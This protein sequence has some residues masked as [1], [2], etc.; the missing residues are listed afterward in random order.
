MR[1]SS[2]NNCQY[3]HSQHKGQD[4][5]QAARLP[6]RT[7]LMPASC[8]K[9]LIRILRVIPRLRHVFRDDVQTLALLM[10]HMRH[11]PEQ[12]VQLSHRLL[13]VAYLRFS[14]DDQGLVEVDF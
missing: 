1:V 4:N 10:H 5:Q 14:L 11:I 8:P 2:K 13:D 7:P 6:S 12:L 3:D 9:L